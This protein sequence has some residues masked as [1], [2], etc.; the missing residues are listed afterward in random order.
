MRLSSRRNRSDLVEIFKIRL[1]VNKEQFFEFN[2]DGRRGRSKKL[3]KK[4]CRLDVRKYTFSNRAVDKWNSLLA[5][6][7]VNCTTHIASQLEPDT[8]YCV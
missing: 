1:Q 2:D 7:S 5:H 4:R 8:K 3:F 6:S